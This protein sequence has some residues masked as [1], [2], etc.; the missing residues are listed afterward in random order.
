MK[1]VFA[2]LIGLV[3]TSCCIQRPKV[4]C[5]YADGTLIT[6]STHLNLI[7]RKLPNLLS[8]ERIDSADI[9]VYTSLEPGLS[10]ILTNEVIR[11]QD[12]I[13][14]RIEWEHHETKALMDSLKALNQFLNA[15]VVAIDNKTG[16]V[17]VH[18]SSK[19]GPSGDFVTNRGTIGGMN[20]TLLYTLAMQQEFTPHNRY[21]Q[22]KQ[23][24][25][26][27]YDDM[28]PDSSINR[29]FLRTFGIAF[30]GTPSIGLAKRYS[31]KLAYTQLYMLFREHVENYSN[32]I[33]LFDAQL[34]LLDLTK[35]WSAF[36]NKG[37]RKEPTVINHIVDFKGKEL[38]RR[39]VHSTRIMNEQT[40]EEMLHLLDYYTHL[41][42]G[43]VVHR[44][45]PNAPDFIGNF[46][47][48]G[49]GNT[50]GFFIAITDDFT[51]GIRCISDDWGLR[52]RGDYQ[53]GKIPITVPIWL[54]CIEKL[55]KNRPNENTGLKPLYK[56][57]N[58]VE[59]E[60][61]PEIEI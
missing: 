14:P 9:K 19:S 51:I 24:P 15:G 59:E 58:F 10:D 23:I 4:L 47:G 7:Y 31:Q 45:F 29:S 38:Y 53:Q 22:M 40:A 17:V 6:D 42:R 46:A 13:Y 2:F 48:F 11:L 25:G 8:Q 50:G 32:S 28:V 16:Q 60:E 57:V 26:G 1:W 21:P 41:G 49:S 20:K 12:S 55:Q 36:Y 52:L 43:T 44:H 34:S 27:D 39:K 18:Y 54:K 5:Y 30:G 35:T 61:V 56:Y 33:F 3:V 37:I